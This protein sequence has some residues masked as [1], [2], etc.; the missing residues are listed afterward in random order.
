MISA[1]SSEDRARLSPYLISGEKLKWVGRPAQGIAFTTID[2]FLIPFG[3][4]WCGFIAVWI[5]MALQSDPTFVLFG[6]PFVIAG[7]FIL[8]GR[9]LIDAWIRSKM[10]Y[11]VTDQR[12]LVLKSAIG[13][14][15]TAHELSAGQAVNLNTNDG[16]KGT[17]T[18]GDTGL[19]GLFSRMNLGA[20]YLSS[21]EANKFFGIDNVSEV[22][23]LV[24]ASK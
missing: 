5:S 13:N 11:A 21:S 8:I 23:K 15:L 2:I 19:S 6:A 7:F 3:L 14:S 18:F 17:I 1:G 10:L 16:K 20:I 22:Y 24:Y 9:F 4:F 12:A